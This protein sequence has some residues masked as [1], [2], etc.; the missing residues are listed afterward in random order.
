MWRCAHDVNIQDQ[1]IRHGRSVRRGCQGVAY[2][3]WGVHI[4]TY[5]ASVKRILIKTVCYYFLILKALCRKNMFLGIR[6]R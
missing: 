5:L 4:V 3:K 1:G 6:L 2:R